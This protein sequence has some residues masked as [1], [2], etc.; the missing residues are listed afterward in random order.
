MQTRERVSKDEQEF[1]E[2]DQALAVIRRKKKCAAIQYQT[3]LDIFVSGDLLSEKQA[4]L[5]FALAGR[6]HE[7]L[8]KER[9]IAVYCATIKRRL[10]NMKKSD[11]F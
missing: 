7:L 10:Q 4:D 3:L 2:A 9:T 1:K 5:L 6:Q 8:R 11:S